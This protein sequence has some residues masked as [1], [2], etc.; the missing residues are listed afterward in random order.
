ME[1]LSRDM[2]KAS[3]FLSRR[4]ARFLVDTYYQ[5]QENRIRAAHQTRACAENSEPHATLEWL[6]GQAEGLEGQV[7]RILD[8]Y[9]KNDPLGAWAR[10]NKGIGPVVAAGLLAHIDFE[11]GGRPI[12]TASAIWRYAG[13]DPSC[14]WEKGQKRPWNAQLK[15]LCAYKIGE[16]FVKVSGKDDAFYGQLYRERKE[17]EQQR[18]ERGDYADQAK[19][20]LDKKRHSKSTEAYKAYSKGKLPRAQIHR[21]AVRWT[22]K[23][24]LSHYHHVG[25]VLRFGKE[26]PKPYVF[27]RLGHADVIDPPNIEMVRQKIA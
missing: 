14:V 10:S 13:L 21:R 19:A 23:L 9:S 26:P 18:N 17:L 3:A 25:Y 24:F 7:K 5:M 15:T 20:A 11:V 16:A 8:A 22:V 12:Q 2:I 6:Q 1:K 27:S 4:E